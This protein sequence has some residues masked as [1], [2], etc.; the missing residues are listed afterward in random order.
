MHSVKRALHSSPLPRATIQYSISPALETGSHNQDWKGEDPR[1]IPHASCL[2]FPQGTLVFTNHLRGGGGGKVTLYVHTSNGHPYRPQAVVEV[3]KTKIFLAS[4]A[5]LDPVGSAH[6]NCH[7][8]R[9]K[10][11]KLNI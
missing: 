9:N 2:G 6:K 7:K 4:V 10:S 11:N 5:D 8:T 3:G 1:G